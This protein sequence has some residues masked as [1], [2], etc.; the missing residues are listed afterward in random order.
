MPRQSTKLNR[1][2]TTYTT[3]ALESILQEASSEAEESLSSQPLPPKQMIGGMYRGISESQQF[4]KT[5][6]LINEDNHEE[7]RKEGIDPYDRSSQYGRS[8]TIGGGN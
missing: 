8:N 1:R 3:A 2:S 6:L 7:M 5:R 4:P